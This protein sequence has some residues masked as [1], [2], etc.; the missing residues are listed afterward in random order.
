MTKNNR[1][2]EQEQVADLLRTARESL[3]LSL[4]FFSVLDGATQ[5]LE[6]VESAFPMVFKDAIVRDQSTTLCQAIL[7][8]KLPKVI[9]DLRK[10][11]LAMSL[12]AAK[13]PRRSSGGCCP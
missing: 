11:P 5:T 8:N 2:A 12:P 13:M 1:T 6:V 4:A 7:D 10:Y 9:P 3:G